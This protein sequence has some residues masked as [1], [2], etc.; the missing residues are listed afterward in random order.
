MLQAANSHA[1][2]GQAA[3]QHDATPQAG[4]LGYRSCCLA[5]WLAGRRQCR[6]AG[7]VAGD[8]TDLSLQLAS[9]CPHLL[10]EQENFVAPR[11]NV[12]LNLLH[13]Q[14]CKVLRRA[15]AQAEGP[16]GCRLAA[17]RPAA[18]IEAL[19]CNIKQPLPAA[20]GCNKAHSL[21]V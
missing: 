4:C 16:S 7:W 1:G 11:R 8:L 18:V 5:V 10:H 17:A 21:A 19:P 3:Q 14:R 12:L 9:G 13:L 20:R 2:E 6:L 15:G